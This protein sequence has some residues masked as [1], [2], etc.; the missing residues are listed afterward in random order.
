MPSHSLRIEAF[1]HYQAAWR[2]RGDAARSRGALPRASG[3]TLVLCIVCASK[4]PF[5]FVRCRHCGGCYKRWT[6][7]FIRIY[8]NNHCSSVTNF[9]PR[10]NTV[11]LIAKGVCLSVT[12]VNCDKTN[13]SSY[14]VWKVN[15]CNFSGHIEWLWWL[16]EILGPIQL[17]KR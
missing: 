1:R 9:L 10:C 12:R 14:T 13:E 4:Y 11:F 17:Q 16:P 6:P 3:L 5:R 7:V 2:T 8:T 15:S